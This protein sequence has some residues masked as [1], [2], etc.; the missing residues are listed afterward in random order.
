MAA[1]L[2]VSLIF[3]AIGV[4]MTRSN[5]TQWGVPTV[6][7]GW[8]AIVIF[9]L[10]LSISAVSLLPGASYLRLETDGYT[11]CAMF[12]RAYTPWVTMRSFGVA[13]VMVRKMVGVNFEPTVAAATCGTRMNTNL[14]GFDGTLP[15]TYGMSA[16]ALADLM[17]GALAKARLRT[18]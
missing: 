4:W 9:G 3:L 6:Y 17:N 1:V 14:V 18:G 2:V 11:T 16:A 10:G 8:F 15:D 13:Q 12:R 7:W 5:D